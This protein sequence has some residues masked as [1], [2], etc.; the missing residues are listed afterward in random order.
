MVIIKGFC[1]ALMEEKDVLEYVNGSCA[2]PYDNFVS[3]AGNFVIF[4][5]FFFVF[6]NKVIEGMVGGPFFFIVGF[7]V[8]ALAPLIVRLQWAMRASCAR[9]GIII[10]FEV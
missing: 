7:F 9:R 10:S 1:H 5:F 4:L 8:G 3:L 2:N 6:A